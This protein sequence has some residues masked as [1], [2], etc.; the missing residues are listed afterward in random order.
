M[1][2]YDD[3]LSEISSLESKIDNLSKTFIACTT[4]MLEAM[5][6]NTEIAQQ[7]GEGLALARSPTE[8]DLE[9]L[10]TLREAYDKYTFVR[11]LALGDKNE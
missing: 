4:D 7:L 11:A 6:I 5:K 1:S 2:E 10:A 8:E 9:R 3:I